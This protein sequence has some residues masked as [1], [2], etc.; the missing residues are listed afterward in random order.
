MANY[1][2]TCSEYSID[3]PAPKDAEG[4]RVLLDTKVMYNDAG[5]EYMVR[6]TRNATMYSP[7]RSQGSVARAM[8]R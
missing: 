3:V 4:R 1:T 8:C 7:G 5:V 2:P 6:S